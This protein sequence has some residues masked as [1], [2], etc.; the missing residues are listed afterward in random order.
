MEITTA[1]YSDVLV[2]YSGLSKTLGDLE[3]SFSPLEFL[4]LCLVNMEMVFYSRQLC[5]QVRFPKGFSAAC[6][7]ND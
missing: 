7:S 3:H 6:S 4:D 5:G 2:D 1:H